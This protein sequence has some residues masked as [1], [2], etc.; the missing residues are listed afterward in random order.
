MWIERPPALTGARGAPAITRESSSFHCCGVSAAVVDRGD[1]H[2][3]MEVVSVWVEEVDPN[4]WEMDMSIEVRQVVFERPA[5]DFTLRPIGSAV[6]IRVASIALVEPL[7]VLAF[8]LEIEGHV[9]DAI[10]SL[11]QTLDL[12][13]VRLEDLRVMLQFA[14]FDEPR[15]ELLTALVLTWIVL[16]RIVIAFPTMRLQQALAAVGQE[17]RHVPLTRH[18]SC[19]DEA[20]LAEVAELSVPRVQ[21]PIFAVA[22]ILGGYHSESSDGGQRATLRAPQGVLAVAIEHSLAVGSARQVQL[23][24][25]HVARVCTVALTRVAISRIFVAL[26]GIVSGSRIMLEHGVLQSRML[27]CCVAVCDRFWRLVSNNR[28]RLHHLAVILVGPLLGPL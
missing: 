1:L 23:A 24:Q 18:P 16:A 17:H 8:E 13:Q 11:E 6:G 2:V 5:L 14:R 26:S 20:Q 3:A 10:T 28:Q 21:R 22:E 7:L 12:V 25:E 15:V 19:V 4:V 9:L 27:P